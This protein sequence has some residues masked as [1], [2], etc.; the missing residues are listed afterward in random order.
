MVTHS[1]PLVSAKL[2]ESDGMGGSVE[3]L[4]PQVYREYDYPIQHRVNCILRGTIPE[5][6]G[7]ER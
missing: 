1:L 6:A 4:V 3:R 5:G 7:R 2:R